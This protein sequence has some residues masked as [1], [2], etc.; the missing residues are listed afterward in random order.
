MQPNNNIH[1]IQIP[2]ICSCSKFYFNLTFCSSS[3]GT[4]EGNREVKAGLSPPNPKEDGQPRKPK[5]KRSATST[6]T[7]TAAAAIKP[8]HHGLY[9][10]Q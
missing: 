2:K 3:R 8:R 10:S 1:F 7:A 5:P 9:R 4:K 6:A